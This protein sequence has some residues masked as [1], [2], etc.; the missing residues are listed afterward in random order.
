M[1]TTP[2]SPNPQP[3]ALP[4]T[5][6]TPAAPINNAAAIPAANREV[7]LVSH[8]NLF[9]WWPVWLLGLIFAIFTFF[10][11]DRL[12]SIPSDAKVEYIQEKNEAKKESV[13]K[14]KIEYSETRRRGPESSSETT[15]AS[16]IYPARISNQ[17]WMG[18]CFVIVLLLTI[19]ITNVPLRGLL[20]LLV[21]ILVVVLALVISLFHI[22]DTI[23]DLI[24]GLK[25]YINLAGYLFISGSILLAWLVALLFF[26]RRKYIIFSP[27]QLKVC[28]HIGDAVRTYDT[29]GMT[30]EKQR[31][32]LF[33]HY[34][35]GFGSGD[36]IIRTSG[37]ERQE[38]KIQNVLGIGWQIQLIEDLI[39]ERTTVSAK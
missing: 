8:S 32:D 29:V 35:L 15:T 9:Y 17:P 4:T 28:E 39:R 24:L 33:R 30:F 13:T 20:S 2:A 11:G 22:W 3:P 5:P 34:I 6:A 23:F 21:I 37:A 19:I 14:Y 1:S 12:A 16:K 31:D 10:E 26:D 36:L 25:I 18:S 7:K 27:G 38:I